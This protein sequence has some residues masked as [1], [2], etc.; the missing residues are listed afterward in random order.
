MTCDVSGVSNANVMH[1]AVRTQ[2]VTPTVD[3]VY[4][5]SSPQVASV[6]SVCRAAAICKSTTHTGVARVSK[7]P[8]FLVCN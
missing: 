7:T 8:L 5:S 2:R 6:V 4:V 3:S 1:Q